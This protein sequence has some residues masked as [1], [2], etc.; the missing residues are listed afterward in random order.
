MEETIKRHGVDGSQLIF[1]VSES[2]EMG[3]PHS[4]RKFIQGLRKLGCRFA[5]DD[6]GTGFASISHLKHLPVDLVKI[7]G[8]FV[9]ELAENEVD[10]TMVLS[11]TQMAHALN[12][13]VIAE[14]VASDRS[15]AWLKECGVDFLQGNYLGEPRRLN[16]I[17]FVQLLDAAPKAA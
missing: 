6:F 16:E 8:S 15:F 17:D 2:Q 12:L 14:H 13:K 3:S 9:S 4:A 7:E 5:L 11:I 1:E 10:Q